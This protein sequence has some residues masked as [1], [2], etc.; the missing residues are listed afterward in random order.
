MKLAKLA[1]LKFIIPLILVIL[2]VI[3]HLTKL[4]VWISEIIYARGISRFW[5]GILARITSIIPIALFEIL[6]ILLVLLLIFFIIIIISSIKKKN[7]IRLSNT[8]M[9]LVCVVLS[10]TLIYSATASANYYREE[11]RLMYYEDDPSND[12][13]VDIAQFFLDDF[14]YLARTLER[15]DEGEIINPYTDKELSELISNDFDKLDSEYYNSYLPYA[16]SSL[17][18]LIMSYNSISGMYFAPTGEA[19]YNDLMPEFKKPFTI[20]HELAHSSGVMRESEA[21]L[22][23]SYI[24]LN[25]DN[26]FV[27]YSGYHSTFGYMTTSLFFIL[28]ED[29]FRDFQEQY[30]PLIDQDY[31]LYYK[32]WNSYDSVFDRIS[33]YIN[34]LY[35]KI[36]GQRDG[37]DSY[38]SSYNPEIID[39]GEIGDQG[40]IIYDINYSPLQRLYFDIYY[41]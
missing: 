9:T 38:T 7:W 21:N 5:T 39:S 35:L 25:S 20:A 27:R 1:K 6:I 23:A 31:D 14:N 8:I 36:Q 22:I 13:Y 11:I 32:F 29:D 37:V 19:I 2:I 34:D 33:S 4:N 17:F 41:Q 15:D 16:K 3:V 40:Q 28:Q 30:D 10:I 12:E 18:S 24:T 26:D